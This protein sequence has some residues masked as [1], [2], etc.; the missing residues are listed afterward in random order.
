MIY[1]EGRSTHPYI[2]KNEGDWSLV[3][4]IVDNRFVGPMK[5]KK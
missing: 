4:K 3:Y 5:F 2:Q 1:A